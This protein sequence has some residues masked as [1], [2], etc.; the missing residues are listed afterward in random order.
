MQ[1]VRGS[2]F[3][4]LYKR[5][6]RGKGCVCMCECERVGVEDWVG[7]SRDRSSEGLGLSVFLTRQILSH[8]RK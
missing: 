5:E 8:S 6:E 1:W 4:S 2:A 7:A 3:V